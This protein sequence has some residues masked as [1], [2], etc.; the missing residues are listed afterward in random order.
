MKAFVH[1]RSH[2]YT[3]LQLISSLPKS[4]YINP[5]NVLFTTLTSPCI[6]SSE[7]E[8]P[9][10]STEKDSPAILRQWGCSEAE[11]SQILQRLPSLRNMKPTN[12]QS[13]LRV[14]CDLGLTSSDLVKI[15]D[16]RPRFLNYR[17]DRFLDE[18][19]QYLHSLFQSEQVLRKA[20]VRNPSLLIYDIRTQIEPVVAMYEQMGVIKDD[21]IPLLVCRPTII[22]RSSLDDVKLG[23]IRKTGVEAGSKMYKHVVTI[24]AISRTET[25]LEKV[26]NF[27]KFGFTEDEVFRLLGLSPVLLTLSI[28]KVQRNMTFVLGTMKLS[29]GV[30]LQNPFLV[31]VNLDRVIKTRFHLGGKIDDM[32]LQPQIKGPLLLKALRMSE[33]RFLKVFIECHPMDVAEELMVFYRTTKYISRLAETS[34][35]KTTRKGF[36]F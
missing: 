30:V 28:D 29:A 32:G 12:L 24:F 9:D 14:L 23:I 31:L 3:A 36:P 16:C 19:L 8:I 18:R 21:L 25:I 17:I 10:L 20:I 35:K 6:S 22:R 1:S 27:E 13:K 5:N 2:L 15:V 34:K 26:T 7:T 33:K 11:I 4:P